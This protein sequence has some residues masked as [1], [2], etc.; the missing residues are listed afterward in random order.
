MPIDALYV[1]ALL[2]EIRIAGVGQE[3]LRELEIVRLGRESIV[4]NVYLGKVEK[5]VAGIRAAFVDIGR[6]RSGFL[7]LG[8][9]G[10]TLSLTEGAAVIVQVRKDAIDDKGA[11]LSARPGIAG[12]TRRHLLPIPRWP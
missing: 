2:G 1:D 10:E 9:A 6:E 11:L 12:R 8:E 7:P 5:V 3:E 4:G